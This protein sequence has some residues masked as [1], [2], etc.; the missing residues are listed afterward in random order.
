LAGQSRERLLARTG[1]RRL[2]AVQLQQGGEDTAE[3]RLVVDDEDLQGARGCRWCPNRPGQRRLTN[4]EC[5]GSSL[6]NTMSGDTVPLIHTSVTE[7][8][9]AGRFVMRSRPSS[10]Q[11][12]NFIFCR[13]AR[14][15]RGYR[16]H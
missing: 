13:Q 2:V 6:R 11:V 10:R 5:H 3:R 9:M 7:R 16:F 14:P 12:A 4:L 15:T 1:A 8:W